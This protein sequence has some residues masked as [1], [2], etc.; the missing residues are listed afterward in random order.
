MSEEQ[1]M[2]R[3]RE[4]ACALIEHFDSVQIF[5]TRHEAGEK[6]G[7]VNI[8]MGQGNFFTRL[9]QVVRWCQM[10]QEQARKEAE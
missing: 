4:A 6:D 1:D 2:E 8:H 5:V 3:V 9:G 10:Q 7:T